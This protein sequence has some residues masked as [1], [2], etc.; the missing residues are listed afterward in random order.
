MDSASVWGGFEVGL[1]RGLLKVGVGWFRLG[2][3]LGEALV[4]GWFRG[5]SAGCWGLLRF[6][7]GLIW[8]WCRV[9]GWV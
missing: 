4:K 2:I 7:R 9:V 8:G 5:W 1:G 6:V 3:G